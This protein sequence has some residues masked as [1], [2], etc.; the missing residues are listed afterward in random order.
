MNEKYTVKG[1]KNGK[2][3]IRITSK[4]EHG[5]IEQ[6]LE[7]NDILIK[8][9]SISHYQGV[10]EHITIKERDL[11]RKPEKINLS[12][13]EEYKSK[14]KTNENLEDLGTQA[15]EL[16]ERRRKLMNEYFK[17]VE[18][19]DKEDYLLITKILRAKLIKISNGD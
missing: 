7:D 11:N 12:Q 13:I 19:I 15:Q 8:D 3:S 5:E 16:E 1:F 6:L 14:E 10:V 2:F 4:K 18:K 17:S 9:C